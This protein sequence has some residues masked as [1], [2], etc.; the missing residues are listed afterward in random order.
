VETNA[1][2]FPVNNTQTCSP[3]YLDVMVKKAHLVI[4]MLEHRLG[5]EQ[6]LQ[7]LN[8]LLSLANNARSKRADP[9]AWNGMV[10]NTNTFTNSI[11][12]VTGKVMK[13]L[14]PCGRFL[15]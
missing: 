12:S 1:F 13:C 4:R 9:K 14:D 2:C 7:V 10:W 11:F 6:L 3:E 15:F 8:K 5:Q